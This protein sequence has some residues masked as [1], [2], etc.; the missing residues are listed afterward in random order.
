MSGDDLRKYLEN[1]KKLIELSDNNEQKEKLLLQKEQLE[2]L[3]KIVN[4][5]E[6]FNSVIEQAQ[7]EHR[8]LL[9]ITKNIYS[10]WVDTLFELKD[11]QSL[12]DN[13][14]NS[15]MN[16]GKIIYD[17]IKNSMV[18]GFVAGME[19]I[20]AIATMK[21]TIKEFSQQLFM[22]VGNLFD[23]LPTAYTQKTT[24][25]PT[26]ENKLNVR[27][28]GG[29]SVGSLE[30]EALSKMYDVIDKNTTSLT[31]KLKDNTEKVGEFYKI[32]IDGQERFV[33]AL[34]VKTE[35]INIG[36]GDMLKTGIVGAGL[37][38]FTASAT[39]K[40]AGS[41]AGLGTIGALIGSLGGPTGIAIGGL[42]G[43][44]LAPKEKDKANKDV[45]ES[46]KYQRESTKELKEVNRNLVLM[47]QDLRPWEYIS[48][49]YFFSQATNRGFVGA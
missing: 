12:I 9:G 6:D 45:D 35:D 16:V 38:G 3:Y 48:D 42:L 26:A 10:T 47:R 39:G 41:G 20:E 7:L 36:L 30:G 31:Y 15:F 13:I 5:Q 23:G 17:E 43:G 22:G 11:G 49:S 32:L 33:S 14:G 25:T 34:H 40:D 27:D 2:N 24:L 21:N 19:G 1:N 44:L 28:A 46:L 4:K 8:K 29:T 18:E 37:G